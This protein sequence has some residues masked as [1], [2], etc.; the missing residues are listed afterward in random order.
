MA[1]IAC[2]LLGLWCSIY[3]TVPQ[4][5]ELFRPP[6]QEIVDSCKADG[7][8]TWLTGNLVPPGSTP[9][10]AYMDMCQHVDPV[11]GKPDAIWQPTERLKIFWN[12]NIMNSGW[13]K[14]CE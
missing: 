10:D 2:H 4:P 3:V 11:T 7:H 8:C 6:P 13:F 5:V 1:G 9:P 12:Q 14:T